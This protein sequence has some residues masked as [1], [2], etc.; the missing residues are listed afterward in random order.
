MAYSIYF[1]GEDMTKDAFPQG[2]PLE[3]EVAFLLWWANGDDKLFVPAFSKYHRAPARCHL[4]E[5]R[6]LLIAI[7]EVDTGVF[8]VFKHKG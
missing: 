1:N 4:Q 2:F 5:D 7:K 8:E 6:G 3:R